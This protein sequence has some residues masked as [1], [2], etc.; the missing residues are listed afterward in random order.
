MDPVSSQENYD[1]A[2]VNQDP[3]LMSML[4][5]VRIPIRFFETS[6]TCRLQPDS[7][8]SSSSASASAEVADPLNRSPSPPPP[9]TTPSHRP[10]SV[11]AAAT[12]LG[13]LPV[14]R[15]RKLSNTLIEALLHSPVS[16]PSSIT[17]IPEPSELEF[18]H[19]PRRARHMSLVPDS[20]SYFQAMNYIQQ[21][22][23]A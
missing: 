6:S 12:D 17:T 18:D 7:S 2:L 3:I 11:I 15:R 21:V 22:Y 9:E 8:Q 19:M 16:R 1:P 23:T 13:P 14:G 10:L 5:D 4:P 20:S